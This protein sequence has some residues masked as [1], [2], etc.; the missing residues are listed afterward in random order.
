MLSASSGVLPA[1]K[2]K[3]E[4][5]CG[6]GLIQED[7]YFVGRQRD[8]QCFCFSLRNGEKNS[9]QPLAGGIDC[10]Q[11]RQQAVAVSWSS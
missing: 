4:N 5:V 7:Y 1:V 3:W 8:D 10:Q 6:I 11:S 9:N 2:W